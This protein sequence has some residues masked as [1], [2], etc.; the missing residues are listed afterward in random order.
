MGTARRRPASKTSVSL[1]RFRSTA[2]LAVLLLS[3]GALSAAA[4]PLARESVPEPLRPWID[5]VLRGHER[6]QCPF[7]HAGDQRVCVW[8]SRLAL[9]LDASGGRFEQELRV[10][11]PSWAP[12]PG[13]AEHWPE[14]VRLGDAPVPVVEHDGRPALRLGPGTHRV[15]GRLVWSVLPRLLGVP[16][17]TGLVQLELEGRPVA[18]PDR[19]EQGRLWLRAERP[20]TADVG[21]RV[22]LHIHR[23]VTDSIPLRL[24]TRIELGVAGQ[25]RELTLGPA[26]PPGFV[27]L[28][29]DGPL[30]A[31]FEDG[32]LRVQVRPG[33]YVLEL[34]ARHEG[35]VSV[36]APPARP[37]A[38]GESPLWAPE[39]IWVFEARPELRLVDLEGVALDPQQTTL[40]GAWRQLPAYRMAPG[41]TLRLIERRRGE[42]DASDRLELVRAWS[43]DFD[44]RGATVSDTLQGVVRASSRLEM[45][46]GTELGRA[47]LGGRDQLITRREGSE[48][49]GIEVPRGALTLSADSRVEGGAR[50]LPAVGWA[51]DVASL[52]ATLEL[53]PGWR[54]LH[55]SGADRVESTWI[56]RWTLLDLFLVL[57]VAIS[58]LRLWGPLWGLAALV[59]L[60]LCVP[61]TGAPRWIWLA[62]VSLEALRRVVPEGRLAQ[63]VGAARALAL[64]VLVLL[65][66][67]FAVSQVRSGLYPAL[68]Q[69]AERPPAAPLSE[70]LPTA[71]RQAA[72]RELE[73]MK[74]ES[75]GDELRSTRAADALEYDVLRYQPDPDARITTGPGVPDWNWRSVALLWSGPVDQAQELRLV[76]LPPGLN[77]LL[78]LVRVGLLVLLVLCALGAPALP[79]LSRHGGSSGA[80][81]AGLL[82]LTVVP[83]LAAAGP[84][85]AD[86]PSPALL[87]ELRQRLLEPPEC[88]PQCAS[89]PRLRLDVR[90]D[91]LRA[92]LDVDVLAETA[93]PLPGVREW[94]PEQVRVDG[95]PAAALLRGADGGLWVRLGPGAHAVELEGALPA[96]DSVELPLPLRPRRVEA[97][98]EGWTLAGVGEDG[99]PESTLQLTREARGGATDGGGLE[100]QRLPA[101]LEVTRELELGLAWR[102]RTRVRRISPADAALV[103]EI[104]LLPGES[105]TQAGLRTQNGRVLV[106]LPPGVSETGWASF[107]EPRS[108][109]ELV[110][111]GDAPW[112]EVWRV[113]ASPVWHV[114][115]EGLPSVAPRDE[116]EARLREWRPW[117][118]ERLTLL[119]E[120]P[121]G[122]GGSTFTVDASRLELRPGARATDATLELALRSSQGGQHTILLPEG[123]TLQSLRVDG[124]ERPPRAE[125]REVVLPLAPGTQN[126]ELV[127]QQP[128]GLGRR[129]RA[130][131]VELGLPSV[132]ARTDVWMSPGRWILLLGGPD[133]GPSVLF[134]PL[135]AVVALLAGLLARVPLTPL[136]FHH[137]LL[138]GLGLTQVPVP[139][140]ALVVA[141]LLA[142]GWRGRMGGRIPGRW[143]DGVQV[144]LGVLTVAALAALFFSIEKGLLGLPEMQI[145]GNGSDALLL[146][147]YQDRAAGTLPRPWVVSAPL[148]VYRLAMLAWALWIAQALVRWLRWG[149]SCFSAGELWRPLRRRAAAA[150]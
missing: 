19:D 82:L 93:V 16:P 87:D 2:P 124:R 88:F 120:R 118:G 69:P 64:A 149:W 56:T 27:P 135:L 92:Q 72:K 46:P 119:V 148:W 12:L 121:E 141:W 43:L 126:V 133:L 105:V 44:G 77:A 84:A 79:A 29:L 18:F 39:E 70:T 102:V 90:A 34:E 58:F 5:W 94:T 150:S 71:A 134:W 1:R 91:R 96:R 83:P 48:H 130:P 146:H 131:A 50:V 137:W 127:W 145:A 53:P 51:H 52:R 139:A 66:V 74:S 114:A 113:D 125:G 13:D 80:A 73:A 9:V 45:G 109:L 78:A 85:R 14:S 81:A 7:L 60:G 86:V 8:P 111:P 100:A 17:E 144:A 4:E 123:A 103:V 35:P 95:R 38:N 142:L 54:L 147:W 129:F 3:F 25:S 115:A 101:F 57:V 26:L 99:R 21:D 136:R 143:L 62:V 107:L 31:R 76:L 11:Q 98:T 24:A 75:F 132:N 32:L 47:A 108:R 122:V 23:Y 10:Y 68:E 33:R 89:S 97:R 138:L 104:P 42:G 61:E 59:T 15:S 140:G 37:E 30:P 106:S 6:E 110:A 65:A 117:P 55:A 20:S 63:T 128:G 67:P 116:R 40:P 112:V 36:L 41:D 22:E 28:A 49:A